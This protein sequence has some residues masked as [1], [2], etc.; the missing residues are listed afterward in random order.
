MT[1]RNRGAETGRLAA[2]DAHRAALASCRLCHELPPGSR[3][4]ISLARAPRIMLVGQAPGKVEQGGGKPFAGRAGRTLFRWFEQAGMDERSVRESIYIAAITRCYPGPSRS[5]RGDRLPSRA[6]RE[7]CSRWLE[8]ELAIIRPRVIIL[9]GR[10]AV[11]RLLGGVPLAS[12]VGRAMPI[13]HSAGESIA[14]ALPHPSGASGWL[15]AP[16]HK[17]LLAG[18]LALLTEEVARIGPGGR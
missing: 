12:V 17:E 9:V 7:R 1:P 4:I 18:A 3:P 6:E 11:D 14:I 8:A 5:G 16:A 15:N 10:L 13:R 2:L